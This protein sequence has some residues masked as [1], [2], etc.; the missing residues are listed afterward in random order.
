MGVW[1]VGSFESDTAL[2][3]LQKVYQN[4]DFLRIRSAL[5]ADFETAEIHVGR[6]AIAAADLVACS[7][8][9][10]PPEPRRKGLVVW[11]R[12]H[13]DAFTPDLVQ[14]A[15]RAVAQIKANSALRDAWKDR[16]GVVAAEWLDAISDLERRLLS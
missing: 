12:E 16:D 9:K 15:Q 11:T 5:T 7:L 4:N 14:L 3:W 1:D 13:S 8:G 10:P 6:E 2:D